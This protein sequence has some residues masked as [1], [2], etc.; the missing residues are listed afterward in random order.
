LADS[1]AVGRITAWGVTHNWTQELSRLLLALYVGVDRAEKLYP[2]RAWPGTVSVVLQGAEKPLPP[3]VVDEVRALFPARPYKTE[4]H[5]GA[6]SGEDIAAL[7]ARMGLASNAWVVGGA[8]TRSGKPLLG[9]DPHLSHLLP[10]MMVQMHISCP[11]LD[12]IGITTPGLPYI[13]IGHNRHVAWGMTSAVA[14][15]IDL[16]VEKVNPQNNDQVL[17][18]GGWKP[19]QKRK[20]VIRIRKD[21]KLVE[22]TFTHRYS[23]NGVFINDLYPGRFPKWAPPFAIHWDTRGTAQ[24]IALLR[25]GNLARNVTELKKTY[26]RMTTPPSVYMAGDVHGRV[27]LFAS[28]RIPLRPHHRGTFPV[29]GW[30]DRYQ[31]KGFARP[32]Q[33]P[34]VEGGAD[35]RFAHGNSL[36]WD[37]QRAPF[38][39]HID[40]A[41]SYR[42]DRIMDL[43]KNRAKH[44]SGSFAQMQT[45]VYLHRARRVLPHI[46]ADL[47]G[48]S[49][50]SPLERKALGLLKDWNYAAQAKDPAPS[51][52]FMTYREAGLAAIKDEV[53][54]VAR[55]FVLTRRYAT[56]MMDQWFDDA[57]HVVWDDRA[58]ASRET[59]PPIVRAAFRRAVAKLA[60]K[61]GSNPAKWRWGR[62]HRLQMRHVFGGKKA[63]AK[64]VNLKPVELSGGM[65]SI[66]KAHFNIGHPKHP[67]K[68]IAGP[69]FRMVVD[70]ADIHHARWILDTGAS[71]WPGSPHYG[72]QHEKWYQGQTV[73]MISDWSTIKRQ[74]KGV[75]TLKPSP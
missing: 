35:A 41:P 64:T 2:S 50:L 54:G 31:W 60:E 46:L 69:V 43:L 32:E 20:V 44:D 14:D 52:F 70:L 53:G 71:G 7:T 9:S 67:F 17:T 61:F 45:D 11:G 62:L 15:A 5:R 28:G 8:H 68:V 1:F 3:A 66:W 21:G 36:L 49:S 59:R 29:P 40:S 27:A 25:Q 26:A 74:A 38:I 39:Y 63:L 18:P 24:S 58:T 13:L 30:L 73:P 47:A 56:H 65:D 37:P 42:M 6:A 16:Y 22:R 48:P 57:R 34:A 19:I 33:L 72:D 23:R 51:V 75:W 55:Q 4:E 10:S 12:A